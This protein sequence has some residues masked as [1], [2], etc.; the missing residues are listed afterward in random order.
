MAIAVDPKPVVCWDP[1]WPNSRISNS[2]C[3]G[4]P[5]GQTNGSQT[6]AVCGSPVAECL[7]SKPVVFRDS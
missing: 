4:I 2:W 3:F 1:Q 6:R 7:Y 5:T